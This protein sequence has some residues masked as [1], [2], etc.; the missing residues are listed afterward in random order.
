ML[1]TR[2]LGKRWYFF[3]K[4]LTRRAFIEDWLRSLWKA[5]QE[6]SNRKRKVAIDVC[7]RQ[8]VFPVESKQHLFC[9]LMYLWHT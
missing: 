7:E 8:V 6:I 9:M 5:K 2:L 4:I 3:F 1:V